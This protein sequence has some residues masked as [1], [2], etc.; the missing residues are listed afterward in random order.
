MFKGTSIFKFYEM[1]SSDMDCYKYLSDLKW[2]K[3]Y[4]CKKCNHDNYCKGRSP[5]SRRCTR[6]KYDE[7]STSGT[8]FH[9]LKFPIL[10]AF[11]IAFRVSVRKKGMSSCELSKEL[12]LRQKTCWA[13][14][15]KLQE[16]MAS[17]R[18]Y[19]LDK[20]TEVD[21]FL[22]GGQSQTSKVG[23]LAQKKRK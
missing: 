8:M 20:V 19:P 23:V 5:F 4:S 17:S 7:S 10:K 9:K 1:F 15:V 16:A 11:H 13:F 14:K 18:R 6:C 21:E 3:G 22:I 2:L 12:D